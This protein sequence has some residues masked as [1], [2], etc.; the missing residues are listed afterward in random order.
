METFEEKYQT[1]I[2]GK[3]KIKNQNTVLSQKN[4][5]LINANWDSRHAKNKLAKFTGKTSHNLSKTFY[6]EN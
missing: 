3:R 5:E 2:D 1:I 4:A 6:I